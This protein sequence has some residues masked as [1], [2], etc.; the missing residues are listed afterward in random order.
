MF[1]PEESRRLRLTSNGKRGETETTR[2]GRRGAERQRWE[3][4][5]QGRTLR[6][7]ESELPAKMEA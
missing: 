4:G 2:W 1:R 6:T 3:G 5:R 7:P